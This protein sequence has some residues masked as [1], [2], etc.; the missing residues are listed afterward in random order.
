MKEDNHY[1]D[2]KGRF[3]VPDVGNKFLK[4]EIKKSTIQGAGLGAFA[5]ERIPKGSEGQYRGIFKKNSSNVNMLYSWVIIKFTKTGKPIGEK[6]LGYIDGGNEKYSNWTRFVNCGMRNNKN[7][8]V[9][10]QRYQ[11]IYYKVLR[12]I[13]K[14]EELFIDYGK[15]YRK[16]ILKM[17]G[18]Y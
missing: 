1:K 5:L 6:I 15:D 8:L 18:K 13:E 14:G 3:F 11:D 12:D 4:I 17:K 2:T 9:A 10:E 16:T 7:N